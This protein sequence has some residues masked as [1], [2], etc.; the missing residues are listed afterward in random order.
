M[1]P[2]GTVIF[3]GR[4]RLPALDAADRGLAY[5]DGLFETLRVHAGRPVWWD[6]HVAR[7]NLG[8]DRLGIEAPATDWLRAQVDALLAGQGE[9]GV[10][11]LVLTRGAGGRGYR[12]TAGLPPTLVLSRHPLPT[13]PSTPLVVRWCG[14]RM[15]LQPALAG[16]KHLNRLEQVLAR[17]EWRDEGIHE[18]LLLDAAGRVACATSANVFARVDGRWL[19]PRVDDC[20]VAGV[21]RSWLL[22][23]VPGA[24]Q[25]TLR[26]ADAN[27]ADALFLCNAV[28]G[29]LPV[30]RLGDR[31]WAPHPALA[32]LQRQLG[33][34]EPAFQGS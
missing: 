26:P 33:R 5:G 2:A 29:I 10:L 25:A 28:R 34:A 7:L 17:A 30:G 22:A 16:I 19:T 23:N 24:A 11:K 27:G 31:T 8:A 14:L 1:T 15:A 6:A 20:G 4:D 9:D 18:G 3:R 21:V 32:E 12:A 13:H